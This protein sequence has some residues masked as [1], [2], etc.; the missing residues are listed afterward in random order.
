MEVRAQADWQIW[1][2]HKVGRPRTLTRA[3]APLNGLTPHYLGSIFGYLTVPGIAG[4]GFQEASQR[5][6][7]HHI[8]PVHYTGLRTWK[9]AKYTNRPSLHPK[10]QNQ[11]AAPGASLAGP[12]A[13]RDAA[14][15]YRFSPASTLVAVAEVCDC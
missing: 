2:L 6:L 7:Q 13:G 12:V 5:E 10:K 8:R 9:A 14:G 11:T 15:G 1:V 3:W 4:G